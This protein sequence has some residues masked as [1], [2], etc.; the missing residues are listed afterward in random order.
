MQL[1]PKK[2]KHIMLPFPIKLRFFRFLKLSGGR[3]N[4]QG[5]MISDFA[6]TTNKTIFS[7]ILFTRKI[8]FYF[9]FTICGALRDL[10]PFAQFK[11][12]EKHPWSSV[13]FSTKSSTPPWMFFTLL[14]LCKWYQI[15]QSVSYA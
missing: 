7:D 3:K 11:K 15:A 6:T 12:R 10:V 5:S 14:K 9:R 13:T 1:T 8:C 2:F 4:I